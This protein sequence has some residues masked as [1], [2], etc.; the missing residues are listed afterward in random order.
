[1]PVR[2]VPPAPPFDN[3]LTALGTSRCLFGENGQIKQICEIVR[4]IARSSGVALIRGESGTGKEILAQAIHLQSPRAHRPFIAVNAGA[5]PP[6]LFESELFGHRKGSFTGAD[7]DRPGRFDE[8]DGGT[9][10]LDEIGDLALA[11]QVK[12]LRVLQTGEV[13]PVGESRPHRVDTRVVAATNRDL[14]ALVRE[15]K[16]REDLYFRL[17]LFTLTIPPLRER[18]EDILPLAR[19]FVRAFAQQQ[20]RAEPPRLDPEVERLLLEYP[21]PGNIRELENCLHFAVTMADGDLITLADLPEHV[22][23][24]QAPFTPLSAASSSATS[25]SAAG[26]PATLGP[27]AARSTAATPSVVL[28]GAASPGPEPTPAPSLNPSSNPGTAPCPTTLGMT[29][30]ALPARP[31]EILPLAKVERTYVLA[32]YAATGRNKTQT[33]RRLGISLRS[34]QMKLKAWGES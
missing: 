4:K 15:G 7:R 14:E 17:N 26:G 32:A 6:D 23:L 19:H 12:L 21:W 28:P 31:E 1:M 10:F 29:G 22:R 25:S 8:A 13:Q 20:G 16:F 24:C 3:P 2:P 5:I 34:L 27:G 11:H 18:R 30:L 33:A 9:L